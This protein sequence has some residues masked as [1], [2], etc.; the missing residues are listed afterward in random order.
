VFSTFLDMTLRPG[1]CSAFMEGEAL[2]AGMT[3]LSRPREE[4]LY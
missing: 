2:F 4:L 1:N 3:K